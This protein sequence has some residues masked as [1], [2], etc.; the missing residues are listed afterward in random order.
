MAKTEGAGKQF[1]RVFAPDRVGH[2]QGRPLDLGKALRFPPAVTAQRPGEFDAW[3]LWWLARWIDETQD[4]T[5]GRAAE[6]AC[7]LADGQREPIALESVGEGLSER[8]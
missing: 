3:A 2:D 5:I 1:G 8:R 4:A 7:S 6:I